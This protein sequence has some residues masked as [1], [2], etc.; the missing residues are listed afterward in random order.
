MS[1]ARLTRLKQIADLVLE[2]RSARLAEAGSARAS[3][4]AR[5]AALDQWPGEGECAEPALQISWYR[6]EKWATPRRLELQREAAVCEANWLSA[7]AEARRAFARVQ[8]LNGL[9]QRR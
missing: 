5:L 8:V 9:S 2:Q 4:Q 1:E 6:F 7:L 3:V